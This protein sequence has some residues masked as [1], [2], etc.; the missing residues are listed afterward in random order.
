MNKGEI[1]RSFFEQF[2]NDEFFRDNPIIVNKF[3]KR[4]EMLLKEIELL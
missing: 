2:K 3:S 4:A 1:P